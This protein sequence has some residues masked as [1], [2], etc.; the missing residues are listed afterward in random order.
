[1]ND[2]QT[3]PD[4]FLLQSENNNYVVCCRNVAELVFSTIL[5]ESNKI[6]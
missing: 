3:S 4:K 5:A 2:S 6:W 1:M